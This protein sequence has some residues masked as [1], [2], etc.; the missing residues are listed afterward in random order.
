MRCS[1]CITHIELPSKIVFNRIDRVSWK[2]IPT[3][4]SYTQAIIVK[5]FILTRRRDS[6]SSYANEF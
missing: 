4:F 3:S 1:N 6:I 5:L 2:R